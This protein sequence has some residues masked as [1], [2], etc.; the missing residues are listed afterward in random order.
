[1]SRGLDEMGGF[2]WRDGRVWED[3]RPRGDWYD[4]FDLIA[5]IGYWLKLPFFHYPEVPEC[6]PDG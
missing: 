1:M 4:R 2:Y 5:G 3:G 6:D